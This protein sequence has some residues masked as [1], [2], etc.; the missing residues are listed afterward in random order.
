MKPIRYM[1]EKALLRQLDIPDFRHMTKEKV[2]I[3]ASS[4][5][6]MDREVALKALEQFPDFAKL[7][8]ELVSNLS[9]MV[10]TAF[11]QNASS[12]QA[13]QQS[14]ND[15]LAY[16]RERLSQ[17]DIPQEERIRLERMMLDVIDMMRQIDADN[18]RFLS[19]LVAGAGML[20]MGV[21]A[22]AGAALGVAMKGNMLDD[23]DPE[24]T[25][26]DEYSS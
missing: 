17:P 22:F 3:F 1:S 6:Y 2:R 21:A 4:L 10:Q 26:D 25:N 24:K 23:D 15:T 8:N 7:A 12:T 5:P 18:K 19:N 14:C 20:C 11:S 13:L 16:C 9:K